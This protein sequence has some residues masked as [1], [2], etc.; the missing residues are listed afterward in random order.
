MNR[1]EVDSYI[2]KYYSIKGDHPFEKYPDTTVYRHPYG[3]KWFAV[4]MPVPWRRL[5]KDIDG[6]V[7]IMNV[8]TSIDVITSF[9]GD[10]GFF[11]AYHMNKSHWISI[12]LDGS[13]S[14]DK[15]KWFINVSYSLTKK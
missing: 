11:P 14:P 2:G 7:Y 6:H 4:V 5:G 3:Q 13:V 15:I 12:A 10:V 1:C 9:L 8:K